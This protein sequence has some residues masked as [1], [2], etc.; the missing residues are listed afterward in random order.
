MKRSLPLTAVL[1]AILAL[2]CQAYAQR[3]ELTARSAQRVGLETVWAKAIPTGLGGKISGVTVYVS[4]TQTYQGSAVVDRF[5]R[6]TFFSDRTVPVSR[7]S[8]YDQTQR[9]SDLKKAELEARGFDPRTEVKQIPNVTVYVRSTAGTVTSLDAETGQENW[10]TVAGTP[11]YPSYS[12]SAN[13][14]Y[15]VTISGST[16]YLLDAVSGEVLDSKS[17]RLI[18]GATPT[19][20]GDFIYVPTSK[21]L[22]EVYSVND[23]NTLEFT[24][25][26]SG[27]ITT[28]I[29]TSPNTASWATSRGHI[30]VANAGAPGLIYHF[31]S[32]DKI[33]ASPV[34]MND[35][36]FATSLDGFAYAIDEE[37]G[38][39]KWRYATGGPIDEAPLAVEDCVYVTTTDG[40]MAAL[41][42]SSGEAKWLASGVDR[43]VSVSDSTVYAVTNGEM[44]TAID[45]TSGARIGS[46]PVGQLGLPVTNT[47]SD[48]VYLVTSSGVLHCLRE[49]GSRFPIA[50]IPVVRE[51]QP[52]ASSDEATTD[53]PA[54]PDSPSAEVDAPASDDPFGDLETVDESEEDGSGSDDAGE[55]D[56]F[57]DGGDDPFGA[58]GDE[59][60]GD[61]GDEE[62]PFGDF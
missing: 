27:R 21:G 19:I 3:G 4:P 34:F 55:E 42:A 25:G 9:L 1:G 51:G 40:Q 48:R 53:T 54:L 14:N 52:K 10:T 35:T 17:M 56:P 36:L 12:V 43:F 45:K 24:V 38:E 5:G 33:A 2:T 50:R 60:F 59:D 49:P 22:V 7:R 62:D 16:M 18:P 23:I 15:A 20:D 11:G 57:G 44:L 28:P 39:V 37:S 31:K 46:A 30:Y 6:R 29:T 47:N 61:M 8:I 32:L 26:S 58:G 13:D 41:D